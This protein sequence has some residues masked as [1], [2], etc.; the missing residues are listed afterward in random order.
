MPLLIA[1]KHVTSVSEIIKRQQVHA[2]AARNFSNVTD[3][4][5]KIFDHSAERHIFH[6][7]M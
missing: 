2:Q 1:C 5:M 4:S 3:N 6:I 7:K